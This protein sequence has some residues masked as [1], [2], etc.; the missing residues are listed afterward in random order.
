MPK[1][2][3]IKKNYRLGTRASGSTNMR[4][5]F[6]KKPSAKTLSGDYLVNTLSISD[7]TEFYRK[8]PMNCEANRTFIITEIDPST[9]DDIYFDEG[10]FLGPRTS[11][12]A[13]MG[14]VPTFDATKQ[15][16][17]IKRA[18]ENQIQYL[19]DQVQTLQAQ[20][21]DKDKEILSVRRKCDE[22]IAEVEAQMKKVQREND[23]LKMEVKIE[24]LVNQRIEEKLNKGGGLSDGFGSVI[25]NTRPL[26][27]SFG[28]AL[29]EALASKLSNVGAGIAAKVSAPPKP[30]TVGSA[31]EE[32]GI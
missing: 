30:Q 5:K 12:I 14:D 20:V 29:G 4:I 21:A 10:M 31:A 27:E 9:G 24:K 26:Q 32:L 6:N 18:Y 2:F 17:D 11:D 19:K 28:K 25:E 3:D 13:S 8:N 22:A 23:E 1:S 7:T 16:A 15:T